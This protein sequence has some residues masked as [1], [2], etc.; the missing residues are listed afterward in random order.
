MITREQLAALRE[1]LSGPA[2]VPLQCSTW[3]ELADTLDHLFKENEELKRELVW[4]CPSGAI[5]AHETFKSECEISGTMNR[6]AKLEAVARAADRF[7]GNCD[8]RN[9]DCASLDK[10]DC[11]V[12]LEE[13]LA[14]LQQKDTSSCGEADKPRTSTGQAGG[15]KNY[16]C[17]SSQYGDHTQHDRYCGEE[18]GE[19]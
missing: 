10:D 8:G 2:N 18:K 17:I 13:A 7:Y 14:A 3:A 1:K 19:Q 15:Y 6:L 12:E 5:S 11:G 4:H 16:C 9:C